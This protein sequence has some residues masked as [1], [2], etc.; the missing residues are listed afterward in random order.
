MNNRTLII[1]ISTFTGEYI[2]LNLPVEFV[3]RV[4]NNNCF[5]FFYYREDAIDSEKLLTLINDAFKYDLTGYIGEIKT[6]DNNHIE[7]SIE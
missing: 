7:L 1:N 5:D 4:I 2:N 6:V 3:K